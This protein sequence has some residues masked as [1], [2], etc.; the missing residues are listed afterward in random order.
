MKTR[1]RTFTALFNLPLDSAVKWLPNE[2]VNTLEPCLQSQQ[3]ILGLNHHSGSR[4][5]LQPRKDEIDLKKKKK[6]CVQQSLYDASL[7]RVSRGKDNRETLVCYFSLNNFAINLMQM[8]YLQLRTYF[9][10]V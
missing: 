5:R 7:A 10:L 4:S 9:T 6:V 3:G 2:D 8:F 1:N